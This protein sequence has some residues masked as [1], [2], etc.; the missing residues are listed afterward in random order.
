MESVSLWSLQ[1]GGSDPRCC[2]AD[3]S[4]SPRLWRITAKKS[5][6]RHAGRNPRHA[7][8]RAVGG[9]LLESAWVGEEDGA[10]GGVHG[11]VLGAA[12]FGWNRPA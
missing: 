7:T 6:R 1:V 9:W 12:R 5:R 8:G 10:E 4:R 3:P 11:R 2:A